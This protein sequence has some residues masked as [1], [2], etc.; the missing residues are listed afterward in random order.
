MVL[1]G[2]GHR[3]VIS[4]PD[5]RHAKSPELNAHLPQ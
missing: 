4:L 5:V 1:R 2:G 3:E